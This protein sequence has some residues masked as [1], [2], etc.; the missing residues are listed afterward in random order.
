LGKICWGLRG[1]T[2]NKIALDENQTKVSVDE[3]H[4]YVVQRIQALSLKL[5]ENGLSGDFTASS[6]VDAAAG[7]TGM[8]GMLF[9]MICFGGF[10]SGLDLDVLGLDGLSDNDNVSDTFNTLVTAASEAGSILLDDSE[11]KKYNDHVSAAYPKG[12]RKAKCALSKNM[13]KRFNSAANQNSYF[14]GNPEAELN[15]LYDILGRMETLLN[16]NVHTLFLQEKEAIETAV[17][18]AS[19]SRTPRSVFFFKKMAC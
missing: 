17:Q 13:A 14:L 12:R 15:Q 4:D 1:N 8:G 2:M 7:D 18:K 3:L 6:R 5:S 10:M 16:N 9:D 11:T 19:T